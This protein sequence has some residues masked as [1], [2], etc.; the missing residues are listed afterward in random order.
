M[1]L[2][3]K[4]EYINHLQSDL[5]EV[6]KDIKAGKILTWWHGEQLTQIELQAMKHDFEEEQAKIL[7]DKGYRPWNEN[8]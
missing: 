6:T 4:R 2:W 5:E 8:Y 3:T 1:K 7:N